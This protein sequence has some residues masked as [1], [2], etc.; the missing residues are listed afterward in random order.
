MFL[1]KIITVFLVA[2]LFV[3]AGCGKTEK[4]KTEVPN[5]MVKY[6][7]LEALSKKIDFPI[8]ELPEDLS[9]KLDEMYIISG[10]IVQLD[11]A[12]EAGEVDIS[13]RKSK[14]SEDISGIYGVDYKQETLSGIPVNVG[15]YKDIHVAWFLYED[16]SY[17]VTATGLTGVS[18]DNL[19]ISITGS[20]KAEKATPTPK[21]TESAAAK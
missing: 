2:L 6:D 13:L 19:L 14:G 20:I 12:D 1:K 7:S 15:T 16:Y 10:N 5:P 21:A 8:A 9:Y 18:F 4:E 11:Y 3:V 17:S